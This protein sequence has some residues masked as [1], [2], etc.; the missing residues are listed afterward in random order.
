MTGTAGELHGPDMFPKILMW[1]VMRPR[2]SLRRARSLRVFVP[3]SKWIAPPFETLVPGLTETCAGP[4]A[5]PS[6]HVYEFVQADAETTFPD[7]SERE[8]EGAAGVAPD[9]TPEGAIAAAANSAAMAVTVTQ[10]SL[11]RNALRQLECELT[12]GP[13]AKGS[14]VPRRVPT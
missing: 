1:P 11:D 14:L 2:D 4:T 13:A 5:P 7:F 3:D 12:E 8:T 9:Q 10:A 6:S